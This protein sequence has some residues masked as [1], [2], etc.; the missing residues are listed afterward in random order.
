MAQRRPPRRHKSSATE[1]LRVKEISWSSSLA[2]YRWS[3][4][5]KRNQLSGMPPAIEKK[6]KQNIRVQFVF[7]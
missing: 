6:V 3:I 1:L 4:R 5:R 2:P 7:Q